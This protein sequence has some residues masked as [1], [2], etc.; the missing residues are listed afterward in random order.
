MLF[1]RPAH[2]PGWLRKAVAL[3]LILVLV[4][5]CPWTA[6]QI[7]IPLAYALTGLC[8]ALLVSPTPTAAVVGLILGGVLGA[9]VYNN[10][11]K[12]RLLD[13]HKSET[14]AVR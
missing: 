12:R 13:R 6:A 7:Y 9:A 14:G 8:I 3:A 5:A 2:L 10:S 11:L 4:P 1:R